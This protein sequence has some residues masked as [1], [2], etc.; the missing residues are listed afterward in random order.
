MESMFYFFNLRLSFAKHVVECNETR[1]Q[2]GISL[3]SRGQAHTT[4]F[5]YELNSSNFVL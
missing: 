3:I 4:E 5:V 1:V 2:N